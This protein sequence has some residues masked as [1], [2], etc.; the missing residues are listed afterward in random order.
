MKVNFKFE[1]HY[2]S[3]DNRWK[4]SFGNTNAKLTVNNITHNDKDLIIDV[5]LETTLM[6]TILMNS[7]YFLNH[8][9]SL[10]K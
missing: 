1:G 2:D 4:Y 3:K 5:E 9:M 6:M 10:L 7:L 8:L